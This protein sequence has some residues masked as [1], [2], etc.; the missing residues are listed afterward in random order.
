MGKNKY[1]L[2]NDAGKNELLKALEDLRNFSQNEIPF[3]HITQIA[4]LAGIEY[5]VKDKRGRGSQERFAHH[6]L[7]N[8]QGYNGHVGIHVIHKGGD[9]ILVRKSDYKKYIYHIFKLI[10]EKTIK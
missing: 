8:Y 3:K 9:Q 7:N 10:I 2:K 5:L 4:A 1:K 6:L